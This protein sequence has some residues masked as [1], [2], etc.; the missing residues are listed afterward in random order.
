MKV[1][2]TG[3]SGFVGSHILDSLRSRNIEVVLLLRPTAE[4]GFIQ[5]HLVARKHIGAEKGHLVSGKEL[6]GEGGA[7]EIRQ[8]SIMEEE[9]LA[10]ALEGVTHVIHCAGLT[11]ARK[12]SEFYEVNHIGTRNLV[13]AVNAA[14]GIS[15]FVHISSL[16]AVGPGTVAKKEDDAPSPVSEYGKSKLAG[17]TEVRTQCRVPFVIVRP[18]GVYGPRDYGFLSLFKAVRSHI[19]PKPGVNQ[20][21]SLVF[22][23]DLAEAAVACL[24]HPNAAGKAYFVAAKEVVTSR[25]LSEEVASQMGNWTVPLPLFS[26]VLWLACLIQEGV[27]SVTGKAH[28]LSLAKYAELRAPGWVCDASLIGRELG[29]E[30]KTMLKAGVAATLQW[31]VQN[32]WL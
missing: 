28:L 6:E 25:E 20:S 10:R 4:K 26:G 32:S 24:E 2:L 8:G 5:E 15:R 23:K 19:L 12:T 18:P 29:F 14:K 22:V 11:R 17:E 16:A 9:S 31:Y 30:C 7:V 3:A 27:S 1:L 21:L 13:K